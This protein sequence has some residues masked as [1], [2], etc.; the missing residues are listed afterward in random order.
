MSILPIFYN[1][2][3]EMPTIIITIAFALFGSF[4][5]F[6][7]LKMAFKFDNNRVAWII[8]ARNSIILG[9]GLLGIMSLYNGSGSR[10]EGIIFIIACLLDVLF[11]GRIENKYKKIVG[12]T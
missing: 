5:L 9:A 3:K 8:L 10:N 4:V 2:N 6:I 1:E 12:K 11:W 7:K